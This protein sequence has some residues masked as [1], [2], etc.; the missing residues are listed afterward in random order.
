MGEHRD[1]EMLTVA[2][3]DTMG[4]KTEAKA[5]LGGEVRTGTPTNTR[6][7]IKNTVQNVMLGT[8]SPS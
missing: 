6:S 3:Q 8:A 7:R 4:S 1:R 5:G 2:P